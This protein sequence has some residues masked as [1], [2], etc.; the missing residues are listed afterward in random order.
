M[1]FAPMSARTPKLSLRVKAF[2]ALFFA[3]VLGYCLYEYF[4]LS[5]P[6]GHACMENRD[7]RGGHCLRDRPF[8][9]FGTKRVLGNGGDPGVCTRRCDRDA[10]CPESMRCFEVQSRMVSF[11][12]N[13]TAPVGVRMCSP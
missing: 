11:G 9:S 6:V 4:V 10:D 8:F 7:C 2:F 12:V 13:S 1:V 5:F 3:A